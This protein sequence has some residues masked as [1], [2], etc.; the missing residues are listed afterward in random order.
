MPIDLVLDEDAL[1]RLEPEWES[2]LADAVHPSIFMTFDYQYAGWRAFHRDDSQ[3]YVVVARD[4][5]GAIIGIAPFRRYRDAGWARWRRLGYLGAF[6]IDRPAP[7][8]RSGREVAFWRMLA[9]FLE[10]AGGAWDLV[11]LPEMPRE[12][13]GGARDA[14]VS[15]RQ[16]FTTTPGSSA[17]GID[18]HTSW[19]D[20][21]ASHRNLRKYVRSVE[22]KVPNLDVGL[23][24]DPSRVGEGF[25]LYTEVESRSWKAG[26]VG[27][28][29]DARHAAFYR[30]LLQRLAERKRV[31][32][33]ILT[34]GGRPVAGDITYTLGRRVFFHHA[35]YDQAHADW[36]PGN[37]LTCRLFNDYMGTGYDSGDFLCGFAEYMRPWCGLEWHTENV[38][39]ARDSMRMR[40]SRF[41][42]KYK[43]RTS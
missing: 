8:V 28:A 40:V 21:I 11:R 35:T 30:D 10:S 9:D 37:F 41:I 1:L 14:F 6:E 4:G 25:D 27:V 16:T 7:I 43:E 36:S 33:R 13:V 22:R 42:E 12:M 20:F 3:P 18:L 32:V 24:D 34:M 15:G 39:I 19:T 2:L 5:A 23:Y 17:I 29:K 31:S 26:K 38:T